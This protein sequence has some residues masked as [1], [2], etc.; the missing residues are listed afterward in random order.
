MH[1]QPIEWNPRWDARP[2]WAYGTAIVALWTL[3][4]FGVECLFGW[5]AVQDDDWWFLALAPALPALL[6]SGP[7]F[8]LADRLRGRGAADDDDDDI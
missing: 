3:P 5:C 8:K 7:L 2:V 4:W 1:L 6:F